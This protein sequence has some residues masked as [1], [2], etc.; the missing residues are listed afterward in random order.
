LSEASVPVLMSPSVKTGVTVPPSL[1]ASPR[2]CHMAQICLLIFAVSQGSVLP[3]TLAV[4][5]HESDCRKTYWDN[6]CLSEHLH[7]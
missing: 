5:T 4:F 1:T 2:M 7:S 3:V 6:Y